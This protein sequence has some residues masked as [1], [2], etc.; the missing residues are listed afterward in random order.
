M[1]NQVEKI[2][3]H[4][5]ETLALAE[6]LSI[7]PEYIELGELTLES[8]DHYGLPVYSGGPGEYA[9]GT[10]EEA[11]QAMIESMDTEIGRLLDNM[12]PGERENT[13]II[14]MGDNG[15]PRRVIQAPYVN[16]QGKGSLYQGGIK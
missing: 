13:T 8:Y 14:F 9:I 11:D 6:Y 2:V 16:A 10:D 12:D 15:T 3:I 1:S 4:S 7:E 5:P